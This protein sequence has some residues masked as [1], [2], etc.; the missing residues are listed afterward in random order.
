MKV[1]YFTSGSCEHPEFITLKGGSFSS[2]HFP[3]LVTAVE[4]PTEGVVL[5]DTGYSTRFFEQTKYFPE[6]F[7]ALV[8][9]VK[10]SVADNA[11]EKLKGLGIQA[12][13]VRHVICSHFHADHVAGI[14]DFK[15]A[16]YI[17]SKPGLDDILSQS[18]LGQV[19]RGFLK[20]LMPSD[21]SDRAQP[22]ESMTT[23]TQALPFSDFNQGWDIFRDG[24]LIAVSLPG[25]MLGQVGLFINRGQSKYD[26]LVADAA[27]SSQAITENRPPNPVTKF[28]FHD[29]GEYR[30]TLAR[31]HHFSVKHGNQVTIVPCHCESA[32]DH[33]HV[34]DQLNS[35]TNR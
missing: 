11:V 31:L 32:I 23:Q 6:K 21:F 34:R 19:R 1:H 8:T 17:F 26:F 15:N 30:R 4:H 35:S 5:F 29:A 13:D 2:Q 24:S 33:L 12:S 25:H 7:Y 27:W 22:L 3:A 18:R 14:S 10:V 20:G 28:L 16:K 9:P